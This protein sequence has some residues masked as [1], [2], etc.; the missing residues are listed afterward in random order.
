MA[1]NFHV[2]S[3]EIMTNRIANLEKEIGK[4]EKHRKRK[5][6]VIKGLATGDEN[7]KAKIEE[8]LKNEMQV[9]VNLERAY[10]ISKEGIVVAEFNK[11]EEKITV[12]KNKNLLKNKQ[13]KIYIDDD[14]TKEEQRIQKAIRDQAKDEIKQGKRAKVGY[15]KLWI[16][17]VVHI[18]SE[19]E[20]K[21]I[22]KN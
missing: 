15:R 7:I 2:V 16:N 4:I 6:I 5:N 10:K 22:P 21:V 13:T 14:Y 3:K 17:D 11:L 1:I 12:M 8:F 9:I 18:W 20:G 19:R